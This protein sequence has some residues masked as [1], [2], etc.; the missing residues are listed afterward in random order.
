MYDHDP[1]SPFY[2]NLLRE[3][4]AE[5]QARFESAADVT[6]ALCDWLGEKWDRLAEDMREDEEAVA[7]ME[8][9]EAALTAALKPWAEDALAHIAASR[10]KHGASEP[11]RI[12]GQTLPIVRRNTP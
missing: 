5:R 8:R 4:Q 11:M 7:E 10:R 3:G 9:I 2:R 6:E 12:F 1:R